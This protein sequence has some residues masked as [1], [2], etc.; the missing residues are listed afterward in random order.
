MMLCAGRSRRSSA[1]PAVPSDGHLHLYDNNF[2][3]GPAR[4]EDE[5]G[6]RGV[7]RWTESGVRTPRTRAVQGAFG[8]IGR[9][10]RRI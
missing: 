5:H 7:E 6:R 4:V 3:T 8:P 2:L 10:R 9:M 1:A